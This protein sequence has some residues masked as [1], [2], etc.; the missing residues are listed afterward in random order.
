MEYLRVEQRY[1]YTTWHGAWMNP[2]PFTEILDSYPKHFDKGDSI[3]SVY[4]VMN[5]PFEGCLI[6]PDSNPVEV[7]YNVGEISERVGGSCFLSGIRAPFDPNQKY[8][9]KMFNQELAREIINYV[10]WATTRYCTVGGELPKN[11]FAEVKVPAEIFKVPFV[12]P[13]YKSQTMSDY[14]NALVDM[15]FNKQGSIL[16]KTKLEAYKEQLQKFIVSLRKASK[17]TE[18]K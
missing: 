18:K 9:L 10:V 6:V 8:L 4:M 2:H 1:L 15:Q 16:D 11:L 3:K 17:D 7:V 14:A 12:E 5:G 13:Y